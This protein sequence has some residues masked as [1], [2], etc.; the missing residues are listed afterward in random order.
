MVV[1][2]AVLETSRLRLQ[3]PTPAD[4]PAMFARYAS[5][6][7]VTK[8]LSWPTHTSLDVTR[9]FI[10]W[11]EDQ[12]RRWPASS[13][14]IFT[15]EDRVLLGSTGLSYESIDR[16]VTGYVL[17]RDAW[18]Q[19]YATESLGA[20]VSLASTLG[21]PRLRSL[22]HVDHRASARVLEKGGFAFT[23]IAERAMPFPNLHPALLFDVHTYERVFQE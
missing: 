16:V 22:C 14:L 15:R 17:A 6:A 10:A 2:P 20:M 5:D 4:A 23:G 11:D 12:W 13:Y 3:R 21:L 9:A 1:A 19:G 7:E 8:Y 18:G